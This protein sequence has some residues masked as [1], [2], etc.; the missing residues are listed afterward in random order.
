MPEKVIVERSFRPVYPS[1]VGL[2]V[3]ADENKKPNIATVAEVFNIGLRDPTYI[4][5]ALR[6]ATYSHGLIVKSGEF[7][8][9]LAPAALVEVADLI[10]TI[11][12]RDGLDKFAEFKLSPVA[13]SRVIPPIIGECPVNLECKLWSLTEVGDHDLFIGEVVCMHVD[14]DKLEE[15]QRVIIEKADPLCYGESG[16]YAMG[17]KLGFHGYSRRRGE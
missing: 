10:G 13:S 14:A 12:G 2:I 16:Y 1:P 9:N 7:T 3:S 11:S 15:G 17:K 5:I 4:G 8:V 6:K